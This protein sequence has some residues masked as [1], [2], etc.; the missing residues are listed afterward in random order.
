MET[1]DTEHVRKIASRYNIAIPLR[2]GRRLVF[3]SLSMAM[4]VWEPHEVAA[5]ETICAGKQDEV[6]HV[7]FNSLVYG[8]FIVGDDIDEVAALERLYQQ[9]RFDVANTILTIAPTMA[10]NFGCDYCFQGQ[11][12]PHKTMGQ[13]VQDAIVAMVE[14]AAPKVK[15]LGVTWYGGEPL[16]RPKVIEALSDRMIEVCERHNVPYNASIV[17][18][19]F[20]LTPE[21]ARSLHQ[22]RVNWMQI[23]LD[24]TPEYHDSRRYLLGG[25]GSFERIVA[26]LQ[27]IV[28]E[29]PIT[30]AIRVNIDDR[31]YKDIHALLDYLDAQGLANKKNL[32]I[33]FAPVEALTEGCHVVQDVT[34]A[35][36]RYGEL[37]AGL[38][39][40]GYRLGLTELPFPPRFH[41]ICGA[42]RPSSF[43]ILPTGELHKCWD[44]VSSPERSIG[45]IFQIEQLRENELMMKWLD[46]SPFKNH[47]CKNCKILP[48]CAGACAYKFIHSESTRNEAAVLPCP[49]WKYNIKERLVQRAE[50]MGKIT[51]DDY[52]PAEIKTNPAELCAD[53]VLGGGLALPETMQ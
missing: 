37:E 16:L 9:T 38:Y 45:S 43:V 31:N 10:C 50:M 7:T 52:D 46:W 11:D 25:K 42:V 6:D 29:V 48:N 36:S 14:R 44:T 39:R 5:F 13:D 8:G 28:D 26:N 27:A 1:M 4:A 53:E 30:I 17:T 33:Y 18:N 41:G 3:N 22:R 35:K 47:T 49:S 21:L 51:A 23:T 2:S 20:M 24:G 15:N 34:M 32:K 12:K 40:H 19:G